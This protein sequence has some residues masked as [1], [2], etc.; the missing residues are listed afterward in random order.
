MRSD[1]QGAA[2]ALDNGP[3]GSVRSTSM[4]VRKRGERGRAA[5][6]LAVAAAAAAAVVAVVAV[7]AVGMAVGGGPQQ[8]STPAVVRTRSR[9]AAVRT[10]MV[11]ATKAVPCAAGGG[12]GTQQQQQQRSRG[13]QRLLRGMGF[14]VMSEPAF[15]GGAGGACG[16]D[17]LVEAG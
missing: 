16:E 5:V 1:D 2:R 8:M 7:V 6:V 3:L 10:A 13:R 4:A 15:E 11:R 9:A 17:P 14:R 12:G